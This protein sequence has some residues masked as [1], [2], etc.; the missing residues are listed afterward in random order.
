MQAVHKEIL[1]K[2]TTYSRDASYRSLL[3]DITDLQS[4]ILDKKHQID[5]SISVAARS[6]RI[7]YQNPEGY[8]TVADGPGSPL[9]LPNTTAFLD[10]T[11]PRMQSED[12]FRLTKF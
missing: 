4:L 3:F 5:M 6:E 2:V 7:F 11:I 1:E 8:Q 12:V 10:I 9:V